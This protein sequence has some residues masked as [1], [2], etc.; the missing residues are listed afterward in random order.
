MRGHRACAF[1]GRR[2]LSRRSGLTTTVCVGSRRGA[3]FF[4]MFLGKLTL[5]GELCPFGRLEV[6]AREVMVEEVDG[7]W[8][9][10]VGAKK[11]SL[12]AEMS[13]REEER[14]SASL[15][16]REERRFGWR[17]GVGRGVASE[18]ERRRAESV[19][20][21][22]DGARLASESWER[23]D[24]AQEGSIRVGDGV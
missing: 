4:R 20:G 22:G 2:V 24:V 19:S 3:F 5:D 15:G 16:T 21:W 6:E 14:T 17:E 9:R 7:A 23:R 18:E 11:A 8:R 13:T 10:A 12:R 1:R